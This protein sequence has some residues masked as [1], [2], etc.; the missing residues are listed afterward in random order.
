VA[1][2]K[3]LGKNDG[4]WN[5]LVSEW[6]EE[7][8]QFDEDFSQFALASWPVLTEC[9]QSPCADEGVFALLDADRHHAVCRANSAYIPGYDGKVLRIRHLL[10]SPYYDFGDASIDEYARTLSK[11]FVGAV[12]VSLSELPSPHI[13]LHLRSL[14]DR[15]FFSHL[16]APLSANEHF[17]DVKVRG[18]WLYVTKA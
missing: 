14:A 9:I 2:L 5:A 7:C 12:G 4:S 8:H 6:T 16:E 17:S 11:F 15:Q 1:S 10:M 18:S 3:K 13:K